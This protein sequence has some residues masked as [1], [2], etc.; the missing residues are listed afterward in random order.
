MAASTLSLLPIPT[1]IASS[2]LPPSNPRAVRLSSS[3]LAGSISLAPPSLFRRPSLRFAAVVSLLPT[4]KPERASA[5]KMPKWSSMAIR[6]FGMAELEARK[7]K[8]PKTGTEALLMGILVEGTNEASKFLRAI[9]ITLFK[10]REEAVKL[11]GKSDLFSFSPEHPPLT[12]SAQRAL[13]WAVDEKLKS[14]EDGEITT[15]HMLLGIWSEKES[16]GYKILASLGFDDQK[17]SEL[18]KSANKDVVMN[19]R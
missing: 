10:V 1:K 18:A 8:Y 16:A 5:E 11:L 14:G 19:S 12:E 3:L 9:G 7:L 13:D 17:A 15:A 2:L 4:A 6:A